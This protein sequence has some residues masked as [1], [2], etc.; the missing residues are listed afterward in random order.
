MIAIH[1]ENL[2]QLN[3]RYGYIKT[4]R[5]LDNLGE[6]IQ[7]SINDFDKTHTEING[8]A[9]LFRKGKYYLMFI[10][11]PFEC[12]RQLSHLIQVQLDVYRDES[13]LEVNFSFEPFPST[14]PL[15]QA[16]S[17]LLG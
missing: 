5:I 10:N 16:L 12:L 8:E 6:N 4:D 14:L 3:R 2:D 7:E 13:G 11:Y 1:F 9:L 17:Q 15:E